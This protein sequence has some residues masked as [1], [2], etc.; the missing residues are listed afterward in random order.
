M[1][2]NRSRLG[3][4]LVAGVLTSLAVNA[5]AYRAAVLLLCPP[6]GVTLECFN[7]LREGMS[8]EQVLAIISPGWFV[9]D[10]LEPDAP[11]GHRVL[12]FKGQAIDITLETNDG[13]VTKGT[14]VA[15]GQV[16]RKHLEPADPVFDPI[17]LCLYLFEA[18]RGPH[19]PLEPLCYAGGLIGASGLV[20]LLCLSLRQ[21]RVPKEPTA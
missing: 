4:I 12:T 3:C 15:N 8:R 11:I 18:K 16:V 10:E 17:R 2:I 21:I 6:P 14:A 20:T 5:L 13:I 19:R 7:L 1:V 9:L